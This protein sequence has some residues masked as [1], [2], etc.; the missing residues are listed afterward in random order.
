MSPIFPT[1]TLPRASRPR[2]LPLMAV[3]AVL[4]ASAALAG[5]A[6]A[7]ELRYATGAT[8]NSIGGS[9]AEV[10][11]NTLKEASDGE[12]SAK[13]YL[14][15]LLNFAEMP[16][17]LN[18]G[19]T[20][21][22]S[23]IYPYFPSEFPYTN[24]IAELSMLTDLL[25]AP[26]GTA[27]LAYAGAMSEYVFLH[28]PKCQAEW[29]Q[30]NQLYGGGAAAS[31]YYL[32]CNTPV[33]T[34]KQLAGKRT[35]TGG[36]QWARAADALGATGVSMSVNE[37]YEGLGQGAVDCTMQ[38]APELTSFNLKE[39]VTDITRG[40]PL[41]IYGGLAGA[42]INLD[43]WRSLTEAQ[44]RAHLRAAA[45]ANADTS[46]LYAQQDQS[47]LKM[48]AD[49]GIRIHQADADLVGKARRFIENDMKTIAANYQKKYGIEDASQ[50]IQTFRPLL[51]KWIGLVKDVDSSEALEEL[52]W[53]EAYS[54]VDVTRYGQ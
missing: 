12:L 37:V 3:S 51:E 33:A 19:I 25:D 18:N 10:Y 6:Q 23:V 2:W 54:K 9:S 52:Y 27:S 14:M 44:R 43:V 47:N 48:A 41:G 40:I 32:L 34:L 22:G 49:R 13:V 15:S 11:A 53:E 39:V 30:Q 42:N 45:A 21:V 50:R 1:A 29:Q 8:P 38:A 5:P 46:W 24:L 4:I 35:R 36:A 28:C 17:G 16:G 20:D 7:R 31:P 26:A